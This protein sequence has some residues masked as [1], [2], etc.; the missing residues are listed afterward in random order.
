MNYLIETQSVFENSAQAN[1]GIKPEEMWL[2]CMVDL[3]PDKILLIRPYVDESG[4]MVKTETSILY[5]NGSFITIKE[6]LE[7]VINYIK[8][9]SNA[10]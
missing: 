4:A 9:F 1:L 7:S 3:N 8:S 2:P 5:H 10:N 6:K